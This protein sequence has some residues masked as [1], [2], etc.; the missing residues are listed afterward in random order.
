MK[1]LWVY[2]FGI[3]LA[4]GAYFLINQYMVAQLIPLPTW[5]VGIPSAIFIVVAFKTII[6]FITEKE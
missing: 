6:L 2:G 5:S 3:A 1:Q 4:F